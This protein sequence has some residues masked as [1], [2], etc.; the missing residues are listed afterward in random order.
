MRNR[1]ALPSR[2][3]LR[4]SCQVKLLMVTNLRKSILLGPFSTPVKETTA[5][6]HIDSLATFSYRTL[7]NTCHR[8]GSM[9]IV[10]CVMP[11]AAWKVERMVV[12]QSEDPYYLH[13]ISRPQHAHP[14][15]SIMKMSSKPFKKQRPN[16]GV[17][18]VSSSPRKSWYLLLATS[19]LP[20]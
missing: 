2:C 5:K 15:P 19:L 18:E 7:L 9:S 8:S 3:G 11:S 13:Q 16:S 6:R 1:Q 12:S 14:R 10:S 17:I 20:H 4:I